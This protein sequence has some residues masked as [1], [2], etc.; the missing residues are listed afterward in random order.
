[1][2][3]PILPPGSGRSAESSRPR[4]RAGRAKT[5]WAT[6][7]RYLSCLPPIP[8]F[9]IR[10]SNISFAS[11]MN[12]SVAGLFKMPQGNSRKNNESKCQPWQSMYFIICLQI[13]KNLVKYVLICGNKKQIWNEALKN[14]RTISREPKW[15]KHTSKDRQFQTMPKKYHWARPA[16]PLVFRE[17]NFFE[18]N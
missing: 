14:L 4:K 9:Q 10:L 6:S 15:T 2:K 1:M 5:S 18:K 3:P 16:C 7:C 12:T 17:N 11:F 13:T 8:P